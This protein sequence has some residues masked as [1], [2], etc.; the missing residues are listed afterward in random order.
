[1]GTTYGIDRLNFYASTQCVELGE[2]ATIRNIPDKELR[3]VRFQRRSVL[4]L[5]EDPVTLAVN[6]AKPIVGAEAS[7]IELLIVATE[8]GLDYG[9]PLSTYVQDALGLGPNCRNFEIKHACFAGTAALQTAVSYV[10][11]ARPGAKALVVMTDIARCHIGE[12]AEITAGAGA[13]A[14]LV[15][16]DPRIAAV[17]PLSGRASKEVYD[18]ARPTP[19]SEWNDPVLSLYSYL[20]LAEAAWEHYRQ[21]AGAKSVGSQFRYMLYH[22]PL[23]SLTER[24]HR[25]LLESG[26]DDVSSEDAAVSFA[27]MVAPSL[28][29]NR[30]LANIYSGS[31]Y[32][33]I[34]GLIDDPDTELAPGTRV[35]CFSYGSG[36]CGELFA[37]TLAATARA[38][39][40]EQRLA[41]HLE[42]RRRIPPDA[43][44]QQILELQAALP[45]SDYVPDATT[46]RGL[47][48]ALYAG[49]G[50]LVLDRVDNHHRRYRWS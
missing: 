9:K 22:A 39:L 10:R 4:P 42:E 2:L 15:S 38:T 18:V 48:E 17:D 34:A 7:D 26:S 28:R 36:A 1:M 31:L 45:L 37:L 12:I 32:A 24:A 49:R 46:P 25:V 41:A 19:T 8:T 13:V 20:D 35:G 33:S 3:N 21:A 27:R 14:L 40:A 6:A 23:T 50:R 30:E 47:Y 5:F 44:E 16:A 43:Y 29:Y 11:S